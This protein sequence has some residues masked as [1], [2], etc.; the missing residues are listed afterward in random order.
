MLEEG[1]SLL[2]LKLYRDFFKRVLDLA[3]GLIMVAVLLIPML[4]IAILIK[5]DSFHDPI[6]FR[7]S[8]VGKN[9]RQ[10]TILKFRTMRVD[11]PHSVATASLTKSATY[12]TRIGGI[13][14]KSSLD[15]LPQ[16]FNVLIG[17]MSLIGPRPLVPS[18]EKV[19]NLRK[20]NGADQVLPGITGLAQVS[21]R[22]EVSGTEKARL[23]GYY[24][25][26]VSIWLD[27]KIFFIT[28]INVI[29]ERGIQEGKG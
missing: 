20:R 29:T 10:F 8:R 17:Q 3:L 22:D 23:D 15:E 28:I 1:L 13:L 27:I 25:T 9:N 21:G 24:A 7:Q 14:R 6:L 26:H 16:I 4:I 11:A 2:P 5:A 18:E 12:I 19:L